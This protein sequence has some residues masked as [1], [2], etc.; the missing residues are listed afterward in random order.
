MPANKSKVANGKQT[1]TETRSDSP[2]PVKQNQQGKKV[3][4]LK[5]GTLFAI[6]YCCSQNDIQ[7]E[8]STLDINK[9]MSSRPNS[10]SSFEEHWINAL[11]F[12]ETL[13]NS[14]IVLHVLNRT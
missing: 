10:N 1:H 8:F 6:H 9:Q 13:Q 14:P 11:H 5:Q 7:K 4:K 3:L 12:E 2:T